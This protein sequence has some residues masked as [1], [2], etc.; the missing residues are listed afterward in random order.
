MVEM[1]FHVMMGVTGG[2]LS[3]LSLPLLFAGDRLK[4]LISTGL[5]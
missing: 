4:S 5:P 1:R 3:F 2:V